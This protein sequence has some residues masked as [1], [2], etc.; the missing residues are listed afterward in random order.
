MN[1]PEYA[2]TPVCASLEAV[3]WCTSRRVSLGSSL[4][5]FS[6]IRVDPLVILQGH[7][8]LSGSVLRTS[9]TSVTVS[10]LDASCACPHR[11]HRGGAQVPFEFHLHHRCVVILSVFFRLL[12]TR[13]STARTQHFDQTRP[14]KGCCSAR[15]GDHRH[16]HTRWRFPVVRSSSVQTLNSLCAVPS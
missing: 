10:F 12:S 2:V 16:R 13:V 5:S 14:Q 8:S 9:F 11:T 3:S 1:L 7:E 4:S 6:R 15:G